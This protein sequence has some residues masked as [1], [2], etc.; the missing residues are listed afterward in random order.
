M[1]CGCAKKKKLAAQATS[2]ELA[3]PDGSSSSHDTRLDAEV[4][5]AKNGGGG[6]VRRA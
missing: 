6:K 2:Y 4:A 1:A 3:M 5:N